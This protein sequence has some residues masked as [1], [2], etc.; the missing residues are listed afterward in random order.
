MLLRSG[1]ILLYFFRWGSQDLAIIPPHGA[2]VYNVYM[3]LSAG[4]LAGHHKGRRHL[5]KHPRIL[6]KIRGHHC[7]ERGSRCQSLI[8]RKSPKRKASGHVDVWQNQ[9]RKPG[10]V[11]VHNGQDQVVKA[12]HGHLNIK[13]S[14]I[15]IKPQL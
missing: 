4:W 5:H 14:G 8:G 3:C 15:E 6:R 11:V 2:S 12:S 9:E 10:P 1:L 7:R 13:L